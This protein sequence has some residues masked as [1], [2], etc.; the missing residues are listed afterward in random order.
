MMTAGA[1][2]AMWARAGGP[3]WEAS[4][5]VLAMLAEIEASQALSGSSAA[6]MVALFRPRKG[7]RIGRKL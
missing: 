7:R 1:G 6:A 2:A 4:C 5:I 3:R